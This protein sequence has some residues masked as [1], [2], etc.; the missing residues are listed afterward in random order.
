MKSYSFGSDFLALR[1]ATGLVQALRCKLQC[2]GVPLDGP[3]N[4]LCDKIMW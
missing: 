3:A 4:I 2:F 1:V